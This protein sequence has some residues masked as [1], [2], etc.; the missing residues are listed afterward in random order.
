MSPRKVLIVSLDNLGD[1]AFAGALIPA[2]RGSDPDLRVGVWC[3]DYASGLAPFLP[4]V[5][6][7]HASDPFWDRSPGRGPGGVLRFLRALAEVRAERYDAA[8]LPNTRWRVALAARLAGIP[9]R[10]GFDQRG[11][12]RWLT[13]AL[14]AENRGTPLVAEWGRLVAPLGANPARAELRLEVPK[15]L[16][17]ARAA[18]S[19]RL[20]DAALAIHPFAGDMRRCAPTAFWAEFLWRTRR[21]GVE[22]VLVLG[23]AGE[24]RAFAAGVKRDGL[25]ELLTAED[26]G[27]RTLTDSLLA[28]SACRAF[29]GHDSGPL[30][31]A[32]GFGVPALGLYL[33]GDWL[34]AMP[35]GRAIS[36]TLRCPFP[37]Q[38]NPAAAAALLSEIF[39]TDKKNDG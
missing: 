15:E 39:R 11:S 26:L 10:V 22:R 3:K 23:A 14:P 27:A 1:L 37:E 30:H 32:C 25:P 28:L 20:G 12:A 9:R 4:G 35:Q 33:P 29:A 24:S 6:R 19:A 2:L 8:L 38:A 34:R 7:A 21:S 16:E 36:R 13:D 17:A 18:L 5:F 31:C